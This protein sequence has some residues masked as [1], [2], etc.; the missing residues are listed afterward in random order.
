MGKLPEELPKA[1]I[2]GRQDSCQHLDRHTAFPA[3]KPA[4]VRPM[5]ARSIGKRLLRGDPRR[6]AQRAQSIANFAP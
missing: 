4:N 1:Q 2:H 3:F 5:H 6:M